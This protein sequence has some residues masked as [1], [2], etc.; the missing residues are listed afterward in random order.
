M[1]LEELY[2]IL[3]KTE[4]DVAYRE[5]KRKHNI[6]CIVYFET[7]RE[8]E[9]ADDTIYAQFKNVQIELYTTEKSIEAEHKVENLL[10]QYEIIY[11]FSEVGRIESENMYEVIYEVQI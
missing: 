11:E 9:L 1:T 7:G 5:F 4:F 10:N 3:K 6:P 8:N 2:A